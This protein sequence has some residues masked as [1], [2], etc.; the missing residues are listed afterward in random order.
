MDGLV[1]VGK[2]TRTVFGVTGVT[3]AV[4]GLHRPPYGYYTGDGIPH[5]THELPYYNLYSEQSNWASR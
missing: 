1:E 4:T 2:P 3:N 5:S